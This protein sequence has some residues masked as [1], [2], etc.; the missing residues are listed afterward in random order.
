MVTDNRQTDN[1]QQRDEHSCRGLPSGWPNKIVKAVT[2]VVSFRK[3]AVAE[4]G[5]VLNDQT[6]RLSSV[7]STIRKG[8]MIIVAKLDTSNSTLAK[9]MLRK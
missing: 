3:C 2:A 6:R 4:S 8:P 7:G 1:R 9:I 5:I